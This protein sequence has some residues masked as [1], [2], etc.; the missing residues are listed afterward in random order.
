MSAVLALSHIFASYFLLLQLG[1]T[2]VAAATSTTTYN[3]YYYSIFFYKKYDNN[4]DDDDKDDDDN[5]QNTVYMEV[6]T[7]YIWTHKLNS[8]DTCVYSHVGSVFVL[9]HWKW[10]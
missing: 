8:A 4:Y 3:Y 6:I 9:L 7:T 10:D 1:W 5:G 2:A